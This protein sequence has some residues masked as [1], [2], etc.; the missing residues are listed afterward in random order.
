MQRLPMA[1]SLQDVVG[2]CMLRQ[3]VA[4][5]VKT[6]RIAKLKLGFIQVIDLVILFAVIIIESLA[7]SSVDLGICFLI[8]NGHSS[9]VAKIFCKQ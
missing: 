8:T 3:A 4:V 7:V 6:L 1:C 9:C 2:F 5:L